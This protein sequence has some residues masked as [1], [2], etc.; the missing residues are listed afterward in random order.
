MNSGADRDMNGA[1]GG[2]PIEPRIACTLDRAALGVQRTALDHSIFELD[3]A[4]LTSRPDHATTRTVDGRVQDGQFGCVGSFDHALPNRPRM[5]LRP[6]VSG[7]Y[8]G[9]Q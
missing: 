5:R 4:G 6:I 9:L 8:I 3:N 1:A 7:H 2:R